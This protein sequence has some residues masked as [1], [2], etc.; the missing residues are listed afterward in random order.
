MCYC[1]S[2]VPSGVKNDVE[3]NISASSGQAHS[4]CFLNSTSAR[5][6]RG[7]AG[8]SHTI[9]FIKVASARIWLPHGHRADPATNTITT[10][11]VDLRWNPIRPL[12]TPRS[13]KEYVHLAITRS[14]QKD[15]RGNSPLRAI[16]PVEVNCRKR[17]LEV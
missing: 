16:G 11:S 9:D 5:F 13:L 17:N 8:G 7:S 6:G 2:A 15:V 3:G 4:A 10:L 14:R 12:A 1:V